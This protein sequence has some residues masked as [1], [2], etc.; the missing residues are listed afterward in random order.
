MML[1][2]FWKLAFISNLKWHMCLYDSKT[3]VFVSKSIRE[4][5]NWEGAMVEAMLRAMRK[6]ENS[7]LLD[8]GGNIGFYSLAAAAA[9]FTV[10]VFEPVPTNAAMVEQ[11][12]QKNGFHRIRLH[13]VAVGNLT[14]EIGMGRSHDNQGGVR[15]TGASATTMLPVRRL[16][17]IL[18]PESRPVYIK[19]DIEGGE[20]DAVEGMID[21]ITNSKL[22]IGVNME[23]GQSRDK[24]CSKWIAKGGFFDVLHNSH[25]LCPSAYE[26]KEICNTEAWD[27]LWQSCAGG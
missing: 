12:M 17:D 9:G 3:D 20:C 16:D 8:I 27:L 25:G 7:T 11:S 1:K 15:H 6:N 24:C 2:C 23:F 14:S 13:T 4:S 5:G 10:D 22:I 18:R 26:Y 19:L 21:Y